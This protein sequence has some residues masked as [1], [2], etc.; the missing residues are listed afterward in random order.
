M[1]TAYN[2]GATQKFD[3]SDLVLG[4]VYSS[5]EGVGKREVNLVKTDTMQIG[6]VVDSSGVETSTAADVYGVLVKTG[7][8]FSIDD[9]A[10]GDTFTGVVVKTG[11]TLNRFLVVDA[12]GEA[13]S[14]E[15]VEAL[16][17]KG[18]KLTNKVLF[19]S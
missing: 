15:L 17:A 19:T 10:T 2:F 5:D 11:H 1:A 8:L 7:A 18:L 13:I 3:Y 6:S 9:V 12:T 16:E 14:D 4:G